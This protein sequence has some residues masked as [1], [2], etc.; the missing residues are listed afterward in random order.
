M[1]YPIE[2]KYRALKNLDGFW[3]FCADTE[4]IGE[5]NKWNNS[6]GGE[7]R[8]L[9]VPASWNEQINELYNF[10]GKGWYEKQV[11]VPSDW[12][13]K[14]V[15]LRFGSVAGKATVFV[16][17][18]LAFS[19]IGT[20]LPFESDISSFLIFG[21][22]NRITVIADSTLDPWSLPPASLQNNEGRAGFNSSYPAVPY[23]FFPYGGI[24]R[25]VWLYTTSKNRIEDVIIQTDI[26]KNTATVHYKIHFTQNFSGKILVK[27][28]GKTKEIEVLN[29]NTAEG[30]FEIENPRLWEIGKG[31]LY[32]LVITTDFDEYTQS[33][34]IRTVKIEGDKFLLNGKPVFFKGFGKHED[35]YIIGKGFNHALWT[36]DFYL[37]NW[38]GANSFRTSHYPYDE[39]IMDLA[40]R[41]G[42]M[43]IDETPFVSLGQRIYTDE[44]LNK[45]TSVIEELYNRDKNHPCVVMWSL[46]NEPHE[47]D[48]K[49]GDAFFKGMFDKIRSLDTT[50]PAT[51]VASLEAEQSPTVKY[52]D[53]IC[54]N[55]YAGWY[56]K[57]GMGE[58]SD[59]IFIE[60]LE[61]YYNTYKKPILLAEFGADAIAGMHSDPA[62]MFTEEYQRDTVLRQYGII[63]KMPF[64]IGA[65]VWAFANFKTAQTIAR[66]V[67]NHKGVFTRDRQPKLLA[68]A[69]KELWNSEE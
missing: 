54:Y 38:I 9:G 48:T 5:Q 10:H 39:N 69:L 25:S 49:E 61:K 37:L 7:I 22:K 46:A 42:I 12:C 44:I 52:C 51:Y 68:H 34:G 11:F 53:M 41:N 58:Q 27:T 26:E 43:I 59:D 4:N 17:G 20:A 28:D 45:A 32:D 31:E 1:L 64:V 23:D 13:G 15:F 36:K 2:N 21:E 65:H 47:T 14:A 18:S 33:Y 24:Q 30:V 56:V 50:R 29:K 63:K 40:D 6:L 3:N 35:F 60:S 16:N 55:K 19:H 57:T 67:D 62:V 66:V 8:Q